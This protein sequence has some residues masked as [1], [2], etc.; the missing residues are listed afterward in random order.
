M[1]KSISSPLCGA[2]GSGSRSG[3][4]ADSA[5]AENILVD[6]YNDLF[7]LRLD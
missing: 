6:L 4:R 7:E 1:A 5:M 2:G 3:F